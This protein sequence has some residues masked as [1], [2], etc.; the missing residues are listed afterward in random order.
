MGKLMC[1]IKAAGIA[2]FLASC[3]LNAAQAG[4][5]GKL[6]VVGMGPA[7]PDL[8]APRALAVIEKADLILCSPG[9]PKKFAMFG[10][11]IDPGKV[12]FDPWKEI[13]G[14]EARALKKKNYQQW[15]EK[16][17]H[18][19][20]KVQ[21]FLVQSIEKGK[22]VVLMDGG[23]PCIYGPSL[24]YLLKGFDEDLFEIIPGMSALNAAGA[25]LKQTLTPEDVRFVLLA[26][27][28]SLLGDPPGKQDDIF[29]YLSRFETTMVLYMSLKSLNRVIKRFQEYYP[30][31]LP[32][33]VVY[34]AG[35]AEKEK[36]LRSTIGSIIQDI[37]KMDEK[38]IGLVI[39]GKCAG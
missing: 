12:A 10:R 5:K 32:I 3:S 22:T 13:F 29:K 24:N 37:K 31:D 17:E 1:L 7:G 4:E 9:M 21:A 28:S 18:H 16:S 8:T 33:A 23:D 34:Y 25:A 36:V 6:Y 35:Y 19:I 26:S 39:V 38:W 15:L 2:L 11:Y 30:L 14:K 20:K 27:A